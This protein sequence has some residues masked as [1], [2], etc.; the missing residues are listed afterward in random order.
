MELLMAEKRG[1]AKALAGRQQKGAKK[2]RRIL[3]NEFVAVTR[4]SQPT[5]HAALLVR[6]VRVRR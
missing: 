4:Y 1:L 5:A 6:A 3:L 2:Q